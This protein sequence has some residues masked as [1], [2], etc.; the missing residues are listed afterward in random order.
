VTQT[1]YGQFV[2]RFK[3][4][5]VRL[6]LRKANGNIARASRLLK[7][8]RGDLWLLVKQFRLDPKTFRRF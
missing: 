6:A 1:L 4:R 8:H 3:R 7:M 2:E 5:L